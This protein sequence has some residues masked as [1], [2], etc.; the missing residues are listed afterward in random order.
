M[1]NS[2]SSLRVSSDSSKDENNLFYK[3]K[4]NKIIYY[5]FFLNLL[6]LYLF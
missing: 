1:T 6:N 3:N 4:S 5:D 2:S